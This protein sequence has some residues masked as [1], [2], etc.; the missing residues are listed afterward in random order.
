M[1]EEIVAATDAALRAVDSARF[2]QTER[3]FHGRFYC[4][5]QG[6]LEALGLLCGGAILEMEYQKSTRHRMTQRPD[7]VFHIPAEFSGAAVTENNFVVWALKRRATISSA[8]EDFDHLDEMF[9]HLGYPLGIFVNV[10]SANTML[11]HY[12]GPHRERLK[13]VAVS[14]TTDGVE[15]NWA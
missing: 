11:E 10:D 14:C 15:V 3:G 2:F 5:L 8:Q 4:S 1:Q 6:E 7:I 12:R 13:G 9:N